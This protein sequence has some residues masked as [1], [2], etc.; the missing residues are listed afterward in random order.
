M[1]FVFIVLCVLWILSFAVGVSLFK[2][3]VLNNKREDL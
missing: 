1:Q 2:E 3:K